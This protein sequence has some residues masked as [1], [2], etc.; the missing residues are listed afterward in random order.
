M[1][2]SQHL[3]N[4]LDQAKEKEKSYDFVKAADFYEQALHV[5]GA[6]DFLKR[7]CWA[8]KNVSSSAT[9][10]SHTTK[11][12]KMPIILQRFSATKIPTPHC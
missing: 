1:S 6:K 10:L 12:W 11:S 2:K 5:V 7:R 4:T 9:R 8:R 3:K